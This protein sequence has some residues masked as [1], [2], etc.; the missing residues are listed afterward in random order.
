M[1]PP[2]CQICKERFDPRSEEPSG[3]VYFQLTEEDQVHNAEMK[4]NKI[5]GHPRGRSW[6]CKEH[7]ERAKKF[8]HLTLKDAIPLI[9]SDEEE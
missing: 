1:R 4:K 2:I 9:K 8:N 7:F 5:D 6:F 3:L